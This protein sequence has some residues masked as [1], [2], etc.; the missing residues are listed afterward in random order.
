MLLHYLEKILVFQKNTSNQEH[1]NGRLRIEYL[2]LT[3]KETLI[4]KKDKSNLCVV[5]ID[6]ALFKAVEYE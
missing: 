2:F 6:E 1:S 5:G 4:L 3:R